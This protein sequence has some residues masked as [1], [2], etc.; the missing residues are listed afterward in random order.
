MIGENRCRSPRTV[1]QVASCIKFHEIGEYPALYPVIF[2]RQSRQQR[3]AVGEAKELH[4]K[5]MVFSIVPT[6]R[7]GPVLNTQFPY[8]FKLRGRT[9]NGEPS[10]EHVPPFLD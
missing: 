5:G 3:A 10:F 9:A 1:Q 2:N 6:N 8:R 7:P 4:E